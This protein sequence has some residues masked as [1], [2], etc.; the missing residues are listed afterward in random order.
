MHRGLK[1]E[2]THLKAALLRDSSCCQQTWAHPVQPL[3][4]GA[5]A[6]PKA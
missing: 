3:G 2:P 1:A 6:G 5:K 4:R